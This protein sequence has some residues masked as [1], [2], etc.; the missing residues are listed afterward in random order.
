MADALVADRVSVQ[1]G[2]R[3]VVSE[4]S[5]RAEPAAVLALVGPNGA[6]KSS[7]LRALAGLLPCSGQ[8][9]FRGESIAALA[10]TLRARAIAYV[11]QQSAL[12]AHL[13]VREVVAQGRHAH[14]GFSLRAPPAREPAVEHALAATG[15]AE[16]AARSFL[17]L[18]GGEQRR[19]LLARAIA[20]EAPVLLLDEPTAG[21]DVA[22]VL[23]FH[24]L[25]RE[26]AREGRAI[27]FVMHDLGDV[28]RHADRAVLLASGRVAAEGPV[29]EVLSAE[30]ISRVYGVR[31]EE[32]AAPRFHLPE[33]P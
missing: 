11:P 15:L 27:V 17:H 6:G 30:P 21:L 28:R 3:P 16:L 33:R 2:G 18:S 20:T 22:H 5:L 9:I 24:A 32:Q 14:H 13:S 1:L 29:A 31:I 25:V 19:V 23:T 4:V 10:P 8:I 26:L 7:L 12:R